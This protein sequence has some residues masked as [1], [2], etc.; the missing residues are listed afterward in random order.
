MVNGQN[1]IAGIRLQNRILP[2][3]RRNGSPIQKDRSKLSHL[4]VYPVKPQ[5]G[6]WLFKGTRP[7]GSTFWIT[8]LT[9]FSRGGN[10]WIAPINKGSIVEEP[11]EEDEDKEKR[12]KKMKK[13]AGRKWLIFRDVR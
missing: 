1:T 3:E 4:R 10:I 9:T 13:K 5:N 2:Q 7:V 12:K 8:P 11:R 6:G